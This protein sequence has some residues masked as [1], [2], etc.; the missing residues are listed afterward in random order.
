MPKLTKTLIEKTRPEPDK[1]VFLWDEEL[2]GFGLRLYPSGRRVY[3]LQYRT[4]K[5]RQRRAVI[6]RHGPLIP[7]PTD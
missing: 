4:K 3:V 6:G 1:E 5:G 7:K 2:P